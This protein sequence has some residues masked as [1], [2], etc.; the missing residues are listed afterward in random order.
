M[1]DYFN[2]L[3]NWIIAFFTNLGTWFK[4]RWADP[5]GP[6]PS[7][8]S[9]YND[10]LNQYK[11]GFGVGGWIFFVVFALLGVAFIGGLLFLIYFFA[12]K[13]IKFYKTE[14]DKDHLRDEVEKLNIELYNALQEKNRVLS[15]QVGQ[16]GLRSPEDISKA[17]SGEKEEDKKAANPDDVR[18]PRLAS[19]DQ[20]YASLD[21]NIALTGEKDISL[22]DLCKRFRLFC[23]SQLGLYYTPETIRALFASMGTSK[24]IILEG[25]SGTGKTSMPYALGRFFQNPATICSVQ[26]SWRDRSELLGFYNEFTKRFSETDFLRA[27]YEATYRQD[28]NIIVLDEMNLA[29]VEYYFAEF[30]SI[31]EMPNVSEWNIDLVA[32]PQPD[33]PKHI[34]DGKLL[35]PQNIWF[36]GTANNDDSTFT[37]TD[38]VYDRAMSIFFDNKGIAFDYEFTEP[39]SMPYEYLDKLFNQAKTNYPISSSVLA[40]FSELDSF[41]IAKFH[42]AFG[43]RIVKQMKDFVP[44]YV[45]CGGTELQAVDYIFCT[46]ILKKFETLNIA[47]LRDELNEL[48]G[49]LTKLFGKNEFKMSRN[50]IQLLIKI[51]G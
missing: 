47:F 18:F 37:I 28:P 21:T 3:K 36:V 32:A 15:L 5:W 49:K 1:S 27:V 20:K 51:N 29:R 24:I 26:P 19:V 7:E 34:K 41:V 30:L 9:F 39:L 46:K 33:D 2:Y 50:K 16:L 40:K 42:L 38:K 43:N 8:F 31:M 25:I 13:Y 6:V 48:D 23:A 22:E 11:A 12:R 17:A 35:I 4:M 44:C 14:V 45:A 10:L